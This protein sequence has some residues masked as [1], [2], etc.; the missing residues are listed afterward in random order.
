M[1]MR[2]KVPPQAGSHGASSAQGCMQSPAVPTPPKAAPDR[3]ATGIGV[4]V[5]VHSELALAVLTA[6]GDAGE[7]NIQQ[8]EPTFLSEE[9]EH[10]ATVYAAYEQMLVA[11]KTDCCCQSRPQI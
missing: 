4:Q 5:P 11:A 7:P 2:H 10:L 3:C 1:A 6:T 8:M 9:L